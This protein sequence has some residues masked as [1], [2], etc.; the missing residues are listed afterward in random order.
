MKF[1]VRK[2][3]PDPLGYPERLRRK[4]GEGG[5]GGQGC[6]PLLRSRNCVRCPDQGD[7]SRNRSSDGV[8]QFESDKVDDRLDKL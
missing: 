8:Y 3:V 7:K 2:E 1:Q 4:V 5:G 6:V